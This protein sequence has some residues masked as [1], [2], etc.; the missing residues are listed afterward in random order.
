MKLAQEALNN[1][2]YVN[3]IKYAKKVL[4]ADPKSLKAKKMI[5]IAKKE[6]KKE[7]ANLLYIGKRHYNNKN[8]D[9]AKLKLTKTNANNE[10][11]LNLI[12]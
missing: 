3:S 1:K 2:E 8:L 7:V 9:K 6:S 12:Q 5:K 11:S 4:K 10:K